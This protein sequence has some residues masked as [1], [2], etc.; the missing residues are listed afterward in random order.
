MH[1]GNRF[2]AKPASSGHRSPP[3]IQESLGR[4]ARLPARTLGHG[5]CEE[6]ESV[7]LTS[8]CEEEAAMQRSSVRPAARRA[9]L[10]WAPRPANAISL[11][12]LITRG[13]SIQAGDLLASH[14]DATVSCS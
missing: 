12:T 8:P 7:R 1:R 6:G 4:V 11:G 5:S 9:L 10:A 2:R 13:G 14:F 3:Q